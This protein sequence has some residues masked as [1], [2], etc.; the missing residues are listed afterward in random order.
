MSSTT[1]FKRQGHSCV[2]SFP[3]GARIRASGGQSHTLQWNGIV[4]AASHGRS[5]VL[6]HSGRKGRVAVTRARPPSRLPRR[7]VD[8]RSIWRGVFAPVN[9]A[10]HATRCDNRISRTVVEQAR[11]RGAGHG[12]GDVRS[13]YRTSRRRCSGEQSAA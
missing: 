11:F 4:P 8:P 10:A 13:P 5:F 2:H 7:A 1:S 6:L 3:G 12:M 9:V